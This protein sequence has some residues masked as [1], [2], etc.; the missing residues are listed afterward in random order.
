MKIFLTGGTGFLGRTLCRVLAENNHTVTVLLRLT[1]SKDVLNRRVT[2]VQGDPAENGPWQEVLREHDAV[3]NLSGASLFR[4]W[5][6]KTKRE[7]TDSRLLTT[8]NIVRSLAESTERQRCFFNASGV[9]YYG[10][11][12]THVLDETSASG[13]TFLARLASEWESTACEAERY[14]HRVVLCRF[15][16]VMGRD[17]GA[18]SKMLPLFHLNLGGTWGEGSQWFSWIHE[19]D[20]ARAFLFL[21]EHKEIHGPVN[22]TAPGAMVNRDMAKLFNKLLGKRPVADRIPA[23]VFKLILG[24]FAHEFLMGQRV[25]PRKLEE[26]GFTFQFPTLDRCLGDLVRA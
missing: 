16:I 23:F 12:E 14:G 26:G 13:H 8:A 15:G 10:Y 2:I 1:D 24:E 25:Y 19:T 18:L 21:M 7:I 22:F 11:D 3:I 20:V 17:G 9:G 5:G 4:R 6:R